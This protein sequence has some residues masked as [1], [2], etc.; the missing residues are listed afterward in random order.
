MKEQGNCKSIQQ[1]TYIGE[2][3]LEKTL[4]IDILRRSVGLWGP[5]SS[6]GNSI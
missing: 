4:T 3:T 5:C 2:I 1:H 6:Q